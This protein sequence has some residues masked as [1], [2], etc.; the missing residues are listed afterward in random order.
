MA[1]T[2][3]HLVDKVF[4][5]VPVRQ[6]VLSVPR[7]LRYLLARDAR[8]LSRAAG[9]F[10]GEVF[11][12][13]RRR[14]RMRFRGKGHAG[15][16]TAVQRFGGSLNL[17]VHLHSIALDGLYVEDPASGA[18]R[19]RRLPEPT[20]DDLDRVLSRARHRILRFLKKE[21]YAMGEEAGGG[22]RVGAAVGAGG[23][24][25]GVGAGVDR[26][27]GGGAAGPGGGAVRGRV[28]IRR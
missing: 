26:A 8:L 7:R 20:K 16:V 22:G 11:R 15:A 27:G 9:M 25:G 24:A 3:A 19:F 21:G 6:W 1:D 13:L 12:D 4:P 18:L 28:P 5:R 2:A 14:G 17:N 23:G 10:V